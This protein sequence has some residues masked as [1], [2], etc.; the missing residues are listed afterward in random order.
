MRRVGPS[1][2][3]LLI[4]VEVPIGIALSAVVLG[5][6]LAVG[7]LAGAGIVLAGIAA[8]QLPRRRPRLTV[9]RGGRAGE[10]AQAAPSVPSLAEAA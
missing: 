5:Q 7:Q 8:L 4:T 6:Q 1:T 10:P 9:L 2:A 3:A